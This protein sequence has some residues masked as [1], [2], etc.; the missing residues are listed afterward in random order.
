MNASYGGSGVDQSTMQLI[1]D[2][3]E[4]LI[5]TLIEEV[6]QRPAVAVAILAGVVGALVGTMLASGV[7]RPRPMHKR[8]VNRVG[9][10][11]DLAALV[12]LGFRLLENPLVRNYARAAVAGQLKKRFSR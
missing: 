8:V 3:L 6:R 9:N 1:I 7:G 11:G 4:E 5:I 12:G 10:V 2:Q